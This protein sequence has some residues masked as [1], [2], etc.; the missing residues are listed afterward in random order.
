MNIFSRANIIQVIFPQDLTLNYQ[1][2]NSSQRSNVMHI[3]LLA[4]QE[5]TE[6]IF[7]IKRLARLDNV[8]FQQITRNAVAPYLQHNNKT[9]KHSKQLTSQ[10]AVF[11]MKFNSIKLSQL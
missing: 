10:L 8:S 1:Q 3:F 11:K 2:I 9:S 4:A 7:Y 5:I 6:S